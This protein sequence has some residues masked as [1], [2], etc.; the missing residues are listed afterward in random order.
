MSDDDQSDHV[1]IDTDDA[2]NA[3]GFCKHCGE[4]MV[5]N[6]PVEMSLFIKRIGAFVTLHEDCEEKSDG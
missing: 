4:R 1:V 6:V 2:P 3:A 5:F